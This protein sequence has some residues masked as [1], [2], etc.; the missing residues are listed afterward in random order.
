MPTLA[1]EEDRARFRVT[2]FAT[3]LGYPT[4]MTTLAD[5]SLLVATSE[6]GT[7]WLAN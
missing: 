2:A 5:G 7:S 1:R 6:G 4:S 3:G